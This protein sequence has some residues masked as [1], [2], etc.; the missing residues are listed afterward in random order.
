M[1]RKTVRVRKSQN[2]YI[3]DSP[4]QLSKLSRVAL[5]EVLGGERDYP[6]GQ[7]RRSRELEYQ[8]TTIIIDEDHEEFIQENGMNFSQFVDDAIGQRIEIEQQ[9][10]ELGE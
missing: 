8:R 7:D 10:S 4:Y 1:I 3:E 6:T 5:D 9:I 2:K